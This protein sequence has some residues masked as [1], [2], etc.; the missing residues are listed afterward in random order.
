MKRTGK[1]VITAVMMLCMVLSLAACGTKD[2]NTTNTTAANVKH[3]EVSV[4]DSTGTEIY[5]EK[6]DTD[7]IDLYDALM[8]ISDLKIEASSSQYGEFITSM[9]GVAQQGD[10]YW[11]YYVNGT[12]ATVGVSNYTIQ[13]NDQIKFALEEYSGE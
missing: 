13:D 10:Y 2:N 9:N 12:Y 1:I 6:V 11:N 8:N 4:Y 7:Q 3:I 5:D